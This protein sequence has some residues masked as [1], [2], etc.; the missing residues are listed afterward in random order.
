MLNYEFPPIG[1]GAG[2]AH[3][4]LLKEYAGNDQLTIDV[5]TS[6][7]EPGF[8][9]ENFS[10]N[11]TIYKVGLHKKSLHFWRKVEVIEWLV[12]AGFH[13]RKLLRENRYDLAHAFF[14]FPTGWLCYR[15]A[16]GLPYMISLR[17]SDVP[18][19]NI[20]LGLDYKL[21]AGLFR[22]IWAGASAIVANSKGLRDLALDFMP[23][24][25]IKVI[26][27]GIDIE[28]FRPPEEQILKEPIQLLT[29]CRLIS[30]KRIDLLIRAA[31]RAKELNLDIQLNIVGE[32][33]L[34]EPLRRLANELELT[35]NVVFMGRV[36]P[37]QMPNV[38]RDNDL[39]VMSSAHEGMSNA[40]LEAMA[41][42][43]PIITTQCEG[44][45]ELIGDNGIVVQEA[46]AEA[47]AEAVMQLA[48]DRQGY[49]KM[50]A[51]ARS[52]AERFSWKSVAESYLSIY[53][54]VLNTTGKGP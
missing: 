32:G 36:P 33:N 38:Y 18:G 51:S 53:D 4:C 34:M 8:Y 20:R 24:L 5:L 52:R 1:G 11:I 7:P 9:K 3:L 16:N 46:H 22:R 40:M 28:K 23:A 44:V 17:G 21:L 26:P 10:E 54:A 45:E 50:S 19:Y 47:I 2:H 42:G 41:S 43:L 25:K 15:S 29:V 12:K 30:R 35:D 48:D 6:A 13:Y 39:F 27:N 14:G 49:K 31:A 37:E